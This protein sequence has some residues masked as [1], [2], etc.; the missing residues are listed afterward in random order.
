MEGFNQEEIKELQRL[1]YEACE[2]ESRRMDKIGIQNCL[3][4][5]IKVEGMLSSPAF[6]LADSDMKVDG[7]MTPTPA[8]A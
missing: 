5:I 6:T 4:F 8:I 1:L 2:V 7:L 3:H